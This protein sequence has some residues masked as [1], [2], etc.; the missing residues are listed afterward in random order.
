MEPKHKGEKIIRTFRLVEKLNF[1]TGKEITTLYMKSDIMNLADVFEKFIE[2]AAN[3]LL[4]YLFDNE[5]LRGSTWQ[6]GLKE[7]GG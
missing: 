2:K 5:L 1:K 4:I 6:E 7:T 3:G